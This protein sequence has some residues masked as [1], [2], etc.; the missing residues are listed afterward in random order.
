[1]T[2]K[3]GT[4][5]AHKC[6]SGHLKKSSFFF[7]NA[8]KINI[9]S[10]N[11]ISMLECGAVERLPYLQVASTHKPTPTAPCMWSCFP[12]TRDTSWVS[13][14]S[15]LNGSK[16]IVV[17]HFDLFCPMENS[18]EMPASTCEIQPATST[19]DYPFTHRHIWEVTHFCV[20]DT[21]VIPFF[22][23]VITSEEIF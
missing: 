3:A 15:W 12:P 9:K 7:T 21:L 14:T 13:L 8:L 11:C 5:A 22:F 1:M 17:A 23:L 10:E 18:S 4:K 6:I 16:F 20:N 2:C 19:A